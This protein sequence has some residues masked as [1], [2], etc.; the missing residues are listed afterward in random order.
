MYDYSIG[1]S[2]SSKTDVPFRWALDASKIV[3]EGGKWVPIWLEGDFSIG[4]MLLDS[5]HLLIFKEGIPF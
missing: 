4:S 1:L 2:Y 3:I 5:T